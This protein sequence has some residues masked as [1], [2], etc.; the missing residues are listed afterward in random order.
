MAVTHLDIAPGGDD[1][2]D[3]VPVVRWPAEA[4]WRDDLARLGR[5]RLLVVAARHAPPATWDALEDW[6]R[7]G[8]DEVEVF[9]RRELLRRRQARRAPA[10]LDGD[11]L[12]RRGGRWVA[13]SPLEQRVLVP[14]LVR[15]GS[16]VSRAELL[17]AACPGVESDE[18]RALDRVIRR[19]RLRL[20][21]LG[22]RVHTVRGSGFLL[23]MGELP[24]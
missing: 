3:D 23:D 19:L 12:L 2:R 5:A 16:L 4:A 7:E 15:P 21:P 8:V 14:L 9:A 20:A 17:D 6:V 11:G 24:G 1:G 22:V 13:V 10:V 18:T